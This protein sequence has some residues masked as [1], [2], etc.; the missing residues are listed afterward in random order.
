MF[1]NRLGINWNWIRNGLYE[2]IR[3]DKKWNK[4]GLG[5]D[6]KCNE[7]QNGNELELNRNGI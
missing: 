4:S 1:D 6:Y 5:I 2:R 7:N 3:M